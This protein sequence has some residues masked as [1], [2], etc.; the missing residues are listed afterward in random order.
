MG[1]FLKLQAWW[2]TGTGMSSNMP[3]VYNYE[4]Y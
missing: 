2:F 4:L 1:L 3:T